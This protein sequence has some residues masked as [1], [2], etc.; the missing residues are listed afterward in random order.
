MDDELDYMIRERTVNQWT[1]R[2]QS[3]VNRSNASEYTSNVQ[4][5]HEK[6][7]QKAYDD[8]TIEYVDQSYSY[9]NKSLIK[10]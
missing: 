10:K 3:Q 9:L 1:N 5:E 4:Q 7:F 8:A 2:N 6:M